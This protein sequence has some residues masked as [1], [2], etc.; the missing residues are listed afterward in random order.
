MTGIATYSAW[1]PV[2]DTTFSSIAAPSING[3]TAETPATTAVTVNAMSHNDTQTLV[4]QKVGQPAGQT[5]TPATKPS[6]G[7]TTT[8]ATEPGAGQTITPATKPSAGQTPVL[9]PQLATLVKTSSDDLITP[10]KVSPRQL[11]APVKT[12]RND[13]AIPTKS[14]PSATAKTLP[15]T[16]DNHQASLVAELVGLSLASLLAGFGLVTHKRHE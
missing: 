9:H 5:T 2:T 10:T 4:Y 13:L 16:N 1:Q 15:Q 7:Q 14:A 3:Y 6:A 12:S 8:P 11:A